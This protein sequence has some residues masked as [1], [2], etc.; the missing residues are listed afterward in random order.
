MEAE[1]AVATDHA[2]A[3][4]TSVPASPKYPAAQVEAAVREQKERRVK[5]LV[6]RGARRYFCSID[7]NTETPTETPL[8][9]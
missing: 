4:R 1:A 6:R 2:D 8:R 9:Q 7:V 5:M 3:L